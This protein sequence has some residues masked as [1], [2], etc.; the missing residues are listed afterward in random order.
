MGKLDKIDCSKDVKLTQQSAKDECDIN[1]I[2]ER[3]KRGA[4]ISHVNERVPQYGDFTQIPTDLRECLM[5]VKKAETAFMSLDAHVRARFQNDPVLLLDFLN[6]PKNRVEAVELGLVEAPKLPVE[7][8]P[9]D[10][11]KPPVKANSGPKKSKA[12]PVDE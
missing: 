10:E 5:Q 4:E 9:V 1:L 3:A 6:D 12:E 8:A 2:V 11:P 7:V